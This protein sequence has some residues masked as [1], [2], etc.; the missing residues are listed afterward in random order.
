M[1]KKICK[2]CLILKEL[3]FFSK[4]ITRTKDGYRIWCKDCE[5]EIRKQRIL[6][7]GGK[8][9]INRRKDKPG[10]KTCGKCKDQ[11]SHSEFFKSKIT[12]DKLLSNCKTCCSNKTKEE[13]KNPIKRATTLCTRYKTI[14]IKKGIISDITPN[15]LLTEI[16]SKPCFYC[17]DKLE[18]RGCDRSNNELG[19]LKNNVVPCCYTCNS[20]K[21]NKFTKEEMLKIGK[22]IKQIKIKNNKYE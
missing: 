10:Y 6:N 7:K 15:F 19:H 2:K 17:G 4:D 20:V 22:V 5:S 16:M 9:H 21:S 13:Y 3:K 11:Q 12:K 18:N 1:E 14:D 8:V